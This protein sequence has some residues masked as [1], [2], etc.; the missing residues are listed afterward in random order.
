M[1][2]DGFV[3]KLKFFKELWEITKK[4]FEILK[5]ALLKPS[6]KTSFQEYFQEFSDTVQIIPK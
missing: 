2:M 6:S 5:Q 4:S 3:G 1:K